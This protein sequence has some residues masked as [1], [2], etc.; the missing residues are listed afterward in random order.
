MKNRNINLVKSFMEVEGR[1]TTLGTCGNYDL[2]GGIEFTA[3]L[4][5]S[6][7]FMNI[8]IVLDKYQVELINDCKSVKEIYD[9]Y[10]EMAFF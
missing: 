6:E 4:D 10:K 3:H 1:L 5:A 9:C 7:E 2:D 8:S